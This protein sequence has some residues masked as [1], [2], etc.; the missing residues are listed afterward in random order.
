MEKSGTQQLT[1][2]P[3]KPPRNPLP[4]PPFYGIHTIPNPGPLQAPIHNFLK[5]EPCTSPDL[6]PPTPCLV[7]KSWKIFT[8][9]GSG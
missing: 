8:N 7:Q 6:D 1:F 3:I 4:D 5:T 2:L 9:R